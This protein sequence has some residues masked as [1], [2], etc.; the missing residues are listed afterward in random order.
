[1]ESFVKPS[2]DEIIKAYDEAYK[3]Q[4]EAI[5]KIKSYSGISDQLKDILQGLHEFGSVYLTLL[6]LAE[7]TGALGIEKKP[8]KDNTF[9]ASKAAIEY[10]KYRIYEGEKSGE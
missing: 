3:R 10:L 7:K 2:L 6:K 5:K 8:L 9:E 4:G 1:M